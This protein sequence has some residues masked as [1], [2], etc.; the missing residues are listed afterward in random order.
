MTDGAKKLLIY[1]TFRQNIALSARLLYRL[2]MLKP[3]LQTWL[4]RPEQVKA[5]KIMRILGDRASNPKLWYI[6][7]R[8]IALAIFIGTFW[9]ILPIPF[10]SILILLSVLLLQVN[11]P[12][13]LLLAWLMNPLTFIPIIWSSFWI[14]SKIFHVPMLNIELLKDVFAQLQDWILHWGATPLDLSI[15]KIL[16]T[17]LVVEALLLALVLSSLSYLLWRWQLVCVWRQRYGSQSSIN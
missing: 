2:M 16:A 5:L 1:S 10:H 4:P 9:G 15:A 3:L 17:G 8:S 7:R 11:L 13:A 12:V 14:G 6:N